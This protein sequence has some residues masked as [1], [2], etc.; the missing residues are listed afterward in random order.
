MNIFIHQLD[1]RL[2][3]QIELQLYRIVQEF[4]S[5]VLKHSRA[6]KIVIQLTRHNGTLTLM[7]EDNGIGFRADDTYKG[8]GLKNI[9]SRVA[10]L[11]GSW[12]T[13]SVL[14]HGTTNIIEIPV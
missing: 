10:A 3:N 4:V 2:N 13:D 12:N 6:S 1:D 14:G 5:N 7:V 8:M 9:Q 11:E